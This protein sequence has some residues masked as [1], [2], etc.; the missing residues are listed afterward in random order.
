MEYPNTQF[1][2]TEQILLNFLIVPIIG[3]FYAAFVSAEYTGSSVAASGS[4]R[5]GISGI[6]WV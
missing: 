3:T 4:R 6:G 1:D 2:K 5:G